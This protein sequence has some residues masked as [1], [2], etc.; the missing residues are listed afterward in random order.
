VQPATLNLISLGQTPSVLNVATAM[1]ALG[2]FSKMPGA[3]PC[4]PTTPTLDV[5][6]WRGILLWLFMLYG[7]AFARAAA[8]KRQLP[9]GM[10]FAQTGALAILLSIGLAACFGGRT[11]STRP[12]ETPTGTYTMTVTGTFGGTGG[13]TTRSVEVTLIVQ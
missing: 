11:S 3:R 13:S 8:A 1:N 5:S 12:A 10:R 7:L 2:P 9:R 4:A 6:R